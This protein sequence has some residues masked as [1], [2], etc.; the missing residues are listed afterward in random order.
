MMFARYSRSE[1]T[2]LVVPSTAHSF[3]NSLKMLTDD[4]GEHITA[5][6]VQGLLT[7]TSLNLEPTSELKRRL[8]P[9]PV[10]PIMQ[11]KIG[12]SGRRCFF[13]S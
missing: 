2:I 1:V 11:M 9:A 3:P 6:R 13:I 7:P 8:F 4:D 10:P 5:P 12:K